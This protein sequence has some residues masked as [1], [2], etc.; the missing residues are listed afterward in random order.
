M[1]KVLTIKEATKI[2]KSAHGKF[3]SQPRSSGATSADH[4]VRDEMDGAEFTIPATAF[5]DGDDE[6]T[7]TNLAK[8]I[9][10]NAK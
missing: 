8:W 7:A 4:Y 2:A 6:R 1:S 9:R 3:T 5:T 10:R